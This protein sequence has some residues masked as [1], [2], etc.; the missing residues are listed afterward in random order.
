[1]LPNI[2][3]I[4][5]MYGALGPMFLTEYFSSLRV[6]KEVPIGVSPLQ[7]L[8]LGSRSPNLPFAWLLSWPLR[9]PYWLTFSFQD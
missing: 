4:C 8:L 2:S 6:F 3:T 1:M 5:Q 7:N 9:I